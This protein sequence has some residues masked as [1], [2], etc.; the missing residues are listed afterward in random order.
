MQYIVGQNINVYI[1][2]VV[3]YTGDVTNLNFISTLGII[4]LN[5]TQIFAQ[6]IRSHKNFMKMER[7]RIIRTVCYFWLKSQ[8]IFWCVRE[9]IVTEMPAFC[10]WLSAHQFVSRVYYNV[11]TVL[12]YCVADYHHSLLSHILSLSKSFSL[13]PYLQF[14]PL[15]ITVRPISPLSPTPSH[16][17][18]SLLFTYSL[19]I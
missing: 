18:T 8:D 7:V 9:Q 16:S 5:S 11:H 1:L 12:M 10:L 6:R 15:D 17:L 13:T 4:T 3:M 2:C 14:I 19:N